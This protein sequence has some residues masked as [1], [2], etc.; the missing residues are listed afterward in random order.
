MNNTDK[1]GF[2]L[3]DIGG[4]LGGLPLPSEKEIR[5]KDTPAA[6]QIIEKTPSGTIL[7]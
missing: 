3:P 2:S 5:R 7:E 6:E 1:E 4:Q